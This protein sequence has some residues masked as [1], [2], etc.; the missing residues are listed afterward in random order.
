M[1]DLY[2]IFISLVIFHEQEGIKYIL[3]KRGIKNMLL[4]FP[5]GSVVKKLPAR[6]GDTGSIPGPGRSHMP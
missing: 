3:K 6:V 1:D 5:G 4:D 2:F